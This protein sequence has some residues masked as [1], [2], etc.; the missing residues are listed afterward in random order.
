[1]KTI[2]L[3]SSK[4]DGK[5]YVGSTRYPL[6]VR[7]G[8]HIYNAVQGRRQPIAQAIASQGW[9]NFEITELR[10]CASAEEAAQWEKAYIGEYQ[11]STPEKGYNQTVD[12]RGMIEGG[13][14]TVTTRK[15]ISAACRAASANR[16][17]SEET[18]AKIGKASANRSEETLN[19]LRIA[20]HHNF[21]KSVG[22]RVYRKVANNG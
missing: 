6:P 4:L 12:G 21:L 22:R 17:V 1:M 9:E 16:V 7:W 19:K 8:Q 2:Y 3:I 20:G 15:R 10:R 11:S 18:R 14:L 5:F 13:Q